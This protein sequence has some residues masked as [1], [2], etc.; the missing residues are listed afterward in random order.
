MTENILKLQHNF[1]PMPKRSMVW[2]T[3]KKKFFEDRQGNKVFTLHTLLDTLGS[4]FYLESEW[5]IC[6]S[7]SLFDQNGKEIFEGSVLYLYTEYD[8]GL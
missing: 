3:V 8:N 1:Q 6:Q 2:D 5:R 4:R 7:T